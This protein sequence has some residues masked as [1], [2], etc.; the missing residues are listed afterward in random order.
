M[1]L[2]ILVVEL[3]RFTQK[4]V[5]RT[6]YLSVHR[7]FGGTMA[8][9]VQD[10]TIV[11]HLRNIGDSQLTSTKASASVPCI[12]KPTLDLQDTRALLCNGVER[13]LSYSRKPFVPSWTRLSIGLLAAF[14][15]AAS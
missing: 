15:A 4:V 10:S 6:V 7:V 5:A 9:W 13:E 11:K 12:A 2:F 14:F 1:F 8:A 3:L